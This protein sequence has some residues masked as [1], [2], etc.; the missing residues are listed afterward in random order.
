MEN[1][2]TSFSRRRFIK[3]SA[4]AAIGLSFAPYLGCSKSLSEQPVMRPFG[5]LNFEVTTMGL[6]GQASIQWTPKDVDPVQIILKAFKLGINY[7]DTSNLYGP[8]Q[9]NYGKAFKE[10][11]LI[12]G[13]KGYNEKL[14]R[15]IFLTSK[16]HIRWAKGGLDID[17][18]NNWTNG[19]KGSHTVDD[20][21]RT[22]SQVFGDGKGNYPQGAYLDMVLLHSITSPQDVDAVYEG[23]YDTDSKAEKIGALAALRDYRDGTNLTGLNPG[24]EK[25]IKHIGFSGHY[26]PP[27]MME[28][29]QRDENNLLEG[30][31]VSVNP[32]DKLNFN[33]QHNVI[34]VASAKNMGIIAMKVFADGALYSKKAEWSREPS[35]VV[36]TVGSDT[37]PFRPLIKYSLTTPGIH[38]AIIGIG[39][40][41]DEKQNCQL[42][43]NFEA[44]Q[45]GQNDMPSSERGEIEQLAASVK[46][47][48]TNY[49]QLKEGGLTTA[50][51]FRIEQKSMDGKRIVKIFWDTAFAG[52]HPIKSYEI[53]RDNK[54]IASVDHKPQTSKE[55]FSFTDN[56]SDKKSHEYIIVSKDAQENTVSSEGLIVS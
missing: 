16:T 55:S 5:K 40:I 51:N 48:K 24:E 17:G 23:L 34:P 38:T 8:S 6:G 46:D 28:I 27:V 29:I 37:L 20:I 22:L 43:N 11:A 10:L 42:T 39:Q 13:N 33:M 1:K 26:S 56:I 54:I 2:L 9:M 25:L 45:V 19:N 21:K 4:G 7:F 53:K 14:R 49:F 36:R 50:R 31:L 52:K 3:T 32:N 30:M 35:H 41:S 15:S 12:P 18:I 47:G 44:A